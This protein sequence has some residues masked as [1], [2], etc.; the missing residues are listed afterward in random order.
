MA[1]ALASLSDEQLVH[2]AASVEREL[3]AARFQHSSGTLENTAGLRVLRR[4]IARL[5]TEQRSRELA[6]GLAKGSLAARHSSSFDPSNAT[7][8]TASPAEEKGGFLKGIV[9]KLKGSE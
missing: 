8:E 4:T 2:R 3:I 7:A 6:A 9:D 1:E 5:K